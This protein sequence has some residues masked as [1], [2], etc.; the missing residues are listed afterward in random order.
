M[1]AESTSDPAILNHLFAAEGTVDYLTVGRRYIII[2]SYFYGAWCLLWEAGPVI[3][4]FVPITKKKTH[5]LSLEEK[6][7]KFGGERD[8]VTSLWVFANALP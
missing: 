8:K 2:W 3:Y 7:T 6:E 4:L 5:K 1:I